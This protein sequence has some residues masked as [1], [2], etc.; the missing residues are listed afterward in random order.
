MENQPVNSGKADIVVGHV[1]QEQAN[2]VFTKKVEQT[3]YKTGMKIKKLTRNNYLVGAGI[4][5]CVLGIYGYT[6]FAV[7]QGKL[8]ED[9]DKVPE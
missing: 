6:M 2:R 8:L 3:T 9:F 1:T 7:K 5:S 4:L